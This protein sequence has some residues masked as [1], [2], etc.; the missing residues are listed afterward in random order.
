MANILPVNPL[1]RLTYK[2][3]CLC[4]GP[5]FFPV[6]C[7]AAVAAQARKSSHRIDILAISFGDFIQALALRSV[8]KKSYNIVGFTGATLLFSQII[9]L[10]KEIKKINRDIFIIGSCPRC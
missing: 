7:L 1:W 8:K 3:I 9:Q 10:L 6:L 5:A 4:F 2:N